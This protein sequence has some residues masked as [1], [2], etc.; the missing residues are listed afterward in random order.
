MQT[1]LYKEYAIK[2][3]HF[4]ASTAGEGGEIHFYCYEQYRLSR[5]N[6]TAWK[7][8]ISWDHQRH[9]EAHLCILSVFT[10]CH[11]TLGEKL[12]ALWVSYHFSPKVPEHRLSKFVWN[13]PFWIDT[14]SL[15]RPVENLTKIKNNSLTRFIGLYLLAYLRDEKCLIKWMLLSFSD[16]PDL[17]GVCLRTVLL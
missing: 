14:Y 4:A 2:T 11:N 1:K 16:I 10:L 5:A 3:E 12:Q 9:C 7:N 15:Q 8:V 13:E 17:G 6:L